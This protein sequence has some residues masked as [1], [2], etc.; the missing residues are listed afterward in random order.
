MSDN[1]P[2]VSVIVP[3]YNVSS[4]LAKCLESI[5][6][7]SF[8]D[9]EVLLIDDGSTDDSPAIAQG[10]CDSDNRFKLLHKK[11]G[12]LSAARNFGLQYAA[13]EFVAFIDSDDYI[14]TDYLSVLYNACINN[15]ADVSYCRFKYSYFKTGITLKARLSSRTG[16][17][18]TEKALNMLIRD[19]VLHSYAWN[20]LYRRTLFADNNIT[21][22]EMYFEDIATSAKVLFHAKALAVTDKYLYFYVKHFGSIM[23]TM[24]TQK[25]NDYLRSIL[26]VRN[27]IQLQGAYDTYKQAICALARKAHIINIYSI[28]KQHIQHFD[29][30]N[31]RRNLQTNGKLYAYI[32]SDSYEPIDGNPELPLTIT[33]PM[34]HEK[35]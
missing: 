8:S 31:M 23:S 21:Y 25:I 34:R 2:A 14:H 15:D 16:V 17:F 1:K 35:K 33:Q 22:P 3:I 26:I 18:D 13:G 27:Y 10:F 5:R 30:K 19:N 7:Q 24:N 28:I 20:K 32:T 6:T 29:F 11:N 9:F 4:Y 12:G